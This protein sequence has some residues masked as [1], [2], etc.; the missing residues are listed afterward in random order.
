MLGVVECPSLDRQVPAVDPLD[1]GGVDDGVALDHP[2]I[3]LP[4][5][6]LPGREDKR[7]EGDESREGP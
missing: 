6:V 2:R 5:V 1:A 7:D 4:D 3:E